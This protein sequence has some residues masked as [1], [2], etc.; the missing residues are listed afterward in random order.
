[1]TIIAPDATTADALATTVSVLG[2]EKGLALV[3][4]L[5]GVEAIVIPAAS[6]A[7]PVQTSGAAAFI[8]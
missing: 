1:M 3:E 5:D 6:N 7:Q 4:G 8:K 2:A